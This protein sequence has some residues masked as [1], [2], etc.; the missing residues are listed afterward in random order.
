LIGV[1]RR[2]LFPALL[3][4][5]LAFPSASVAANVHDYW[6]QALP[7]GLDV[8][9]VRSNAG[10][11]EALGST[12]TAQ[13]PLTPA[14][15][16]YCNNGAISDVPGV[17]M[18]HTIWYR[19]T[20][21]GEPI[22]IDLRGSTI[23]TVVGVYNGAPSS[24]TFVA[25]DND[26]RG[27]ADADLATEV[28]FDSVQDAQYYVQVGCRSG[29]GTP[30]GNIDFEAFSSPAN[31]FQDSAATLQNHSTLASRTRGATT[32]LN[33]RE[34]CGSSP[35]SRTVWFRFA[36]PGPGTAIFTASGN[37]D[38]VLA[39][40]RGT[41]FLACNDDGVPSVAGASR[42]SLHV[43]TG[44]YMVQVGGYGF[45]PDADYGSFGATV[46]F[47]ADPIPPPPD[48]DS[49]GIPDASDKCPDQNAS[50]RDANRDGCL[51]PDPDPDHDG[52][53][54]A[55]DR[56]PTQ[57]AAGRDANRDGCLDK[58][59]VKE[60]NGARASLRATPTSTGIRV[61]SLRVTAPRGAKALV[62]CGRRCTFAKTAVISEAPVATAARVLS[63]KRL[64]GRSFRAGARI[65]IYVS[66]KNRIGKYFEYRVTKGNFRKIERCLAPGTRRVRKCP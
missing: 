44:T 20:G 27:G 51:D 3:L 16:G 19:V 2:S 66:K 33:E 43:T 54:G 35:Y 11:G 65:K 55:A 61:R 9:A 6:T 52:V 64:A 46:D 31:D 62:R 39:V 50:A 60:L 57:N 30:E 17:D 36:A 37:F 63:F 22:T 40:Y 38:S 14:G 5:L 7:V 4:A 53:F 49:D 8:E 29:C 41:S 1:A 56:C 21:D 47:S 45:A 10:A 25:C 15:V 59:P 58:A 13:E 32:E 28:T 48:R 26:I 24:A 34:A 12:G 18:T 42:L 23:D